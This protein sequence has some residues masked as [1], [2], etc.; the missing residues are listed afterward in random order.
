MHAIRQALVFAVFA[1]LVPLICGLVLLSTASSSP[2]FMAMLFATVGMEFVLLLGAAFAGAL[3]V[4]QLRGVVASQWVFRAAAVTYGIAA[5]ALLRCPLFFAFQQ[6]AL[7][8][9]L[10]ADRHAC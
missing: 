8:P 10:V 3:G 7:M 2:T 5:S 6:A 1:V 4:L 9:P